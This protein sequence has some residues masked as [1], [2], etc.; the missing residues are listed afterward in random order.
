MTKTESAADAYERQHVLAHDLVQRIDE[1]LFDLPAPGDDECPVNWGHVGDLA[2]I[3][4]A[5]AD[6]AERLGTGEQR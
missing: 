3:T 2:Y 4:S 6:V 1:L 5:L